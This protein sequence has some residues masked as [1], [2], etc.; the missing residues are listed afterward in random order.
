MIV[1]TMGCL[2]RI[3]KQNWK[4]YVKAR[5]ECEDVRLENFQGKFIGYIDHNITNWDQEDFMNQLQDLKEE[6]RKQ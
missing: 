1:S 6:R 4:K 5:T 3:S 2:Y